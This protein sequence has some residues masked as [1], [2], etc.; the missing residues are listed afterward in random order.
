[1]NAL[2]YYDSFNY[3]GWV[4]KLYLLLFWKSINLMKIFF[5]EI[6]FSMKMQPLQSLSISKDYCIFALSQREEKNWSR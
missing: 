1:M 6:E 4:D 3:T 2:I 5:N